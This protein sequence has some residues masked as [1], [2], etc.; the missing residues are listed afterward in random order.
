MFAPDIQQERFNATVALE[1]DLAVMFGIVNA[2]HGQIV[3]AMAKALDQDLW[4]GWAIHSPAQWLAWQSGLSPSHAQQAVRL[5]KRA[6]ELP[7]VIAALVAGELSLDQATVIALH[8]PAEFDEDVT[9]LARMCTVEQLRRTLP[10]YNFTGQLADAAKIAASAAAAQAAEAAEAAGEP[11]P[12]PVAA[13]EPVPV[14]EERRDFTMGTNETGWWLNGHLPI[15][16]GAIVERALRT[17]QEDLFRQALKDLPADA[18]RPQISLVDALIN[19]AEQALRTGQT[20]HPNSDRYI[21]YAHLEAGPNPHTG[22][23]ASLHLGP[24]LPDHLKHLHTCDATLRPVLETNGT[25][26]NVGRDHRIIPQRTRRLIE[27]RANGCQTPGCSRTHNLQIHHI[28]HWEN[29]G[30]TDTDNLIALCAFHHRAHHTGHLNITG[31][32]DQPPGHPQG[33]HFTDKW[34]RT[35]P[36]ASPPTPPSPT[37]PRPTGAYRH[38]L[39][40]PLDPTAVCFY[41]KP[42]KQA[43]GPP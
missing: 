23:L 37:T 2:T 19:I 14:I 11:V 9:A 30:K 28:T 39:G 18:P 5:A 22:N 27:Q 25:P 8:V 29:G 15:D 17:T 42:P 24:T 10:R 12:E 32:P 21:I 26:T 40:E 35:L 38:P 33:L 36:P 16:Q 7:C 41:P 43:P 31:N 13:P 20:A 4:Q 1:T 3:L 34:S 6:R